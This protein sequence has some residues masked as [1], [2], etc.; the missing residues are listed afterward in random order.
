[1]SNI[2]TDL[3]TG[4]RISRGTHGPG[5]HHVNSY[6]V[7]AFPWITG[8]ALAASTQ[9]KISFPFVT[10]KVTVWYTGSVA[11][12]EMRVHFAPDETANKVVTGHH[13]IVLNSV[14]DSYD[15][16]VKCKEVYISRP[17]DGQGPI[18]YKVVAE[19]T[20]IRSTEMYALSGSGINAGQN[21]S[22]SGITVVT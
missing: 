9:H 6:L 22:G 5:V 15:F 16:N 2:V 19:L 1:M 17:A 8:S 13:Y 7:S 21:V 12:A 10:K 3:K 14:D 11:N 20:H 18:E 4:Q